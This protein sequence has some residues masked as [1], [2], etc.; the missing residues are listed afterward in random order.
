MRGL[1][2]FIVLAATLNANAQEIPPADTNIRVPFYNDPAPRLTLIGWLEGRILSCFIKK[3]MTEEQATKILGHPDGFSNLG[4]WYSSY[5][6]CVES[7][8]F[9]Y[10]RKQQGDRGPVSRIPT[11]STCQI[12]RLL[13][14]D[15]I[16]TAKALLAEN[17]NLVKATDDAGDTPLHVAT[18][19]GQV[20]VV[21]L[22]LQ[23][24][25]DANAKNDY[26]LTPLHLATV[27]EI[28][29][30]LIKSN[31]DLEA[32]DCDGR[33]ALTIRSMF[34]SP[35]HADAD[36]TIARI[37]VDAGAN[38][39]ICSAIRLG[40]EA[41]V[42]LL[43]KEDPKQAKSEDLL[44]DGTTYGHTSIVKLLLEY[45]ADP[46]AL[47]PVRPVLFHALR[48]PAIAR[49]LLEA[50]ADANT[51]VTFGYDEPYSAGTYS[52]LHEAA[53]LGQVESAK[54]LLAHGAR[55]NAKAGDG[56]TPLSW[57]KERG[58]CPEMIKLL[59]EHGGSE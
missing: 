56:R 48:Y 9:L 30:L 46:N 3:G 12:Y 33:T 23:S 29:R 57:A 20:D 4:T 2:A 54:L 1:L 49:I 28:A 38:Y 39:D 52:L 5:G 50:G 7:S 59:R 51:P 42:R 16:E 40:D 34:L 15:Q 37:L 35:A 18:R 31:A 25:A 13:E 58:D 22:L 45:K 19:K 11:P 44:L 55:V 27:P 36:R 41:R 47:D 10:Y 21:K 53:R 6:V 14:K 32:K 24:R 17:P 26:K 43:L 8:R